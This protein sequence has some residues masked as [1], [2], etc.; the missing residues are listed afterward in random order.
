[1]SPDA[2]LRDLLNPPAP[3]PKPAEPLSPSI[4]TGIHSLS[5]ASYDSLKC[6]PAHFVNFS[7]LKKLK[8]SPKHYRAA[9]NEPAGELTDPMRLG[10]AT[11][12]TTLE[13]ER[14]PELIAVW[15]DGSRRGKAWEA[16]EA[17]NRARTIITGSM[18]SRA[19]AVAKA[20]REHPVAGPLLDKGASEVAI[21]FEQHLPPVHGVGGYSF[22]CKARLDRVRHNGRGEPTMII[23]LKTAADAQPESFDRSAW[24]LDYPAQAAWLQDGFFLATGLRLPVTFIVAETDSPWCVCVRPV[25]LE[26][27]QLGRERYQSWL[28]TLAFCHRENVWNEYLTAPQDLDVPTW[29][30]RQLESEMS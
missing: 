2:E 6:G 18:E 30:R 21:I 17:E 24:D 15:N 16:F 23:D 9:I 10:I 8:R 26:V 5:R 1:M 29:V 7:T 19:N 22:R 25:P 20:V 27:M 12:G 11:H 4:K 28:E 14:L 13:P 3:E